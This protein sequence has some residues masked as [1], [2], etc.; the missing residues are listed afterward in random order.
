MTEIIAAIIGLFGT[1]GVAYIGYRQWRQSRKDPARLEVS[2]SRRDTYTALWKLVE[3]IHIDLRR[4][5]DNLRLLPNRILEVNSFVLE[6]EVY[7]KDGDH[8]LVNSYLQALRE[9]VEWAQ[10]EGDALTKAHLPDTGAIPREALAV[11][12]AFGFRDQLK[13]RVRKALDE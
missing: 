9:M 2:K 12:R 3:K 13:E 5:P 1:L 7:L 10:R 4:D 6:N 8:E 11:A